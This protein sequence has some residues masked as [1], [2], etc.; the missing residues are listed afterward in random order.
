MKTKTNNKGITKITKD[1]MD[2]NSIK[3]LYKLADTVNSLRGSLI[4]STIKWGYKNRVALRVDVNSNE[5][6]AFTNGSTIN[7]FPLHDFFVSS[8]KNLDEHFT[9]VMGVM[10][11]EFAHCLFTDFDGFNKLADEVQNSGLKKRTVDA[12]LKANV[13]DFEAFIKGKKIRA[14]IFVNVIANIHNILEDGYIEESFLQKYA[15]EMGQSL[16]FTR[17][18]QFYSTTKLSEADKAFNNKDTS[19]W[20]LISNALLIYAKYGTFRIDNTAELTNSDLIKKVSPVFPIV[21]EYIDYDTTD[22]RR[23]DIVIHLAMFFWPEIRKEI[24]LVEE[25]AEAQQKFEEMLSKMS[26]EEFDELMEKLNGGAGSSMSGSCKSRINSGSASGSG[27]HKEQ[28]DDD[29]DSSSGSSSKSSKSSSKSERSK[30]AAAS[31]SATGTGEES[32]EGTDKGEKS[33]ADSGKDGKSKSKSKGKDDEGKGS[34][35]TASADKDGS[36]SGSASSSGSE[37]NGSNSEESNN[38][39]KNDNSS[40]NSDSA[41]ASSPSKKLKTKHTGAMDVDDSGLGIAPSKQDGSAGSEKIDACDSSGNTGS[42][43]CSVSSEEGGRIDNTAS[44]GNVDTEGEGDSIFQI[45]ADSGYENRAIDIENLL[46]K[47]NTHREEVATE[48]AL[49]EEEKKRAANIPL[50]GMHNNVKFFIKRQVEVSDSMK[51][52]YNAIAPE[53]LKISKRLRK[54]VEQ[55]LKDREEGGKVNHLK[56]GFNINASDTYRRDGRCFY[57]KNN[58]EEIPPLAIG[59]LL[60]ESGSMSCSNRCTYARSTAIIIEDFAR[61]LGLP[62]FIMGHSADQEY[63]SNGHDVE[64]YSYVNPYSK[65]KNDKFRLMDIS[66][67]S[68]NRDG[69]ALKY[70]GTCLEERPEPVKIL[71]VVSDGQPAASGYYGA[72]ADNDVYEVKRA[73]EKKGI[74][75]FSA[76][77]GSDKENIRRIYKNGFMD[78]TSL[79]DM[80]R[81]LGNLILKFIKF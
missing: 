30:N 18:K 80:P 8:S 46:N 31:R 43:I 2:I 68:G 25:Q 32:G 56:F 66:A 44:E 28:A 58:P 67:R 20:A 35:E 7:L 55:K 63:S 13:K 33:K 21:D 11:H 51:D 73:L 12:S 36:E 27:M 6:V 53:L 59:L 9:M 69:A 10:A 26:P 60:D 47:I 61:N 79:S 16:C 57:K 3:E 49:L 39:E 19:K 50:S 41:F 1:N 37:K 42:I 54:E 17:D 24:E 38:G 75:V 22:S 15:G 77:I 40:D 72:S 45:S 14:K 74:V 65:D 71:I 23:L 48:T 34:G 52:D 81:I 62:C 76:A 29:K 5:A 64:M 4:A 78:I 70:I